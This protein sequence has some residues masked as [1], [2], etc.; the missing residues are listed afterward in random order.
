[1]GKAFYLNYLSNAQ[2]DKEVLIQKSKCYDCDTCL[3]Q[4]KTV[5]DSLNIRLG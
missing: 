5:H 1:M 2:I 3:H 4:T